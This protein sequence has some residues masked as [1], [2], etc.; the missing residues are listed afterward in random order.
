MSGKRVEESS[1][2]FGFCNDM[3]VQSY[4]N[5]EAKKSSFCNR[6]NVSFRIP[7]GAVFSS[8]VS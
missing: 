8:T 6:F 3:A 7:T 1:L 4:C 5:W 2:G